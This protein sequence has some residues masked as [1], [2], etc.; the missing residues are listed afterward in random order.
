MAGGTRWRSVSSDSSGKAK[1]G[2]VCGMPPNFVPMVSTGRSRAATA[3]VPKTSAM[4][5]LGKTRH[6]FGQ[7]RI[8][9][10]QA[11]LSPTVGQLMVCSACHST[12]IC[13]KNSAGIFSVVSPRK[14]L[15]CESRISTAMPLVKPLITDTGMKRI[16]VPMR[17]SPMVSSITPAINVQISRLA[18]P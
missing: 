13:A 3:T 2:N 15:N 18:T 17:S 7:V 16:Q 6:F 5:G 10:R 9:I 4:I 1:V 11:R 12:L 8:R 14:S